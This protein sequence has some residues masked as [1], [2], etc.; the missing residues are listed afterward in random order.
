MAE[1]RENSLSHC[2]WGSLPTHLTHMLPREN[3]LPWKNTFIH[4]CLWLVYVDLYMSIHGLILFLFRSTWWLFSTSIMFRSFPLVS[5]KY[6]L[7]STYRRTVRYLDPTLNPFKWSFLF[8]V[9]AVNSL[10]DIVSPCL[11]SFRIWTYLVFLRNL[12]T[13]KHFLY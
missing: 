8:F 13:V 1:H 9:S 11:T 12:M 4:S 5:L 3:D 10:G 6:S 2:L 7:S